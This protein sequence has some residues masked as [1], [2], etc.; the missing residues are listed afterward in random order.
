VLCVKKTNF[1]AKIGVAK[2]IFLSFYTRHKK[3]LVFRET[4]CVHIE[5]L[6]I[7]ANFFERF[8]NIYLLMGAHAAINV[9]IK[10]P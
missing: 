7:R 9:P 5:C 6:D 4:W 2:D 3:M 8:K 10:F 1:G